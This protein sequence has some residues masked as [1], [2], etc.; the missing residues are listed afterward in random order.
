MCQKSFR[1]GY[2]F[3]KERG[4]SQIKDYDYPKQRAAASIYP[5]VAVGRPVFFSAVL[6]VLEVHLRDASREVS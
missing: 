5:P 2:G 6:E 4:I 3:Q 1:A